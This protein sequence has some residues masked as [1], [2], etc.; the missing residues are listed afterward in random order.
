MFF[1]NSSYT[2]LCGKSS[3][4]AHSHSNQSPMLNSKNFIQNG[5]PFKEK[6]VAVIS[7]FWKQIYTYKYTFMY[8][9]TIFK[10]PPVRK[11]KNKRNERTDSLNS[12]EATEMRWDMESPFPA[13]CSLLLKPILALALY[14]MVVE[15]WYNILFSSHFFTV[16]HSNKIKMLNAFYVLFYKSEWIAA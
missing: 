10:L 16:A 4:W 11:G 15:C 13:L 2:V 9:Y 1:Y 8:A 7:F 5:F 3:L 12:A 14:F 6:K